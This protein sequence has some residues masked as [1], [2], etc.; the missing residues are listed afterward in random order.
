MKKRRMICLLLSLA[1]LLGMAIT[2]TWTVSA[3]EPMEERATVVFTDA[4]PFFP[5]VDVVSEKRLM[6]APAAA[7]ETVDNGLEL[8][9][10]AAANADGSYTI[11]MEAYTTGT[12]TTSTKTTPVD[13]VL[14]LDQSGSMA[15]G[16][17]G[18]STSQNAD[19][20][21][22]A[23]KQA[24]NNFIDAVAGKYS[25]EADHRMSIVTFGSAA[26]TLRGWTNVDENGKTTLK[27]GI[28]GLPNS[29]SG[30]T[31]VAAGMERAENL[32]GSGYRYTGSNTKRQKVVIVFTDG[33]P[34][35]QSDFNTTV[36]TN[37]IAS[38]K[39]L[40]DDGTTVYTVGIF[41]GANP[42][43]LYGEKWDYTIYSDIPCTG[44]VG[45]YWGGS[46]LSS[47]IGTNDFDGIDIAAGNRFLNYL[48]SNSSD[49]TAIGLSRGSFNPGNRFGGDGTGYQ[50]T[51]NFTKSAANYYLTAS[52]ST[53]LNNIFQTISDNIQ[54]ANIDLGSQTVVKDT[55]SPYFDLPA[56]PS[57]INLYTAEARSDGTF[58]D[59]VPASGVSAA[60]SNSTVSVT[61]FDYNANFVSDTVKEDGTY[62]RK[63]IIEFAVTPKSG[64]IGGNDVPTN[65]WE[66]S[67]VYDKDD[68][69][70]EQFA[71][72][73]TT[74]TVNVPIQKPAFTVSDRTIYEGNSVAVSDLY[75]LPDTTG[76]QYDFVSVNVS[77]VDSETVSAR[78]CTDYSIHVTYAP[79]T[80]GENSAGTVNSMAG[81]STKQTVSVHVLKPAVT[82][83]VHDVEKYYGETYELGADT[84]GSI[85]LDWMDKTSGHIDIPDA[86]GEP[87]YTETALRFAYTSGGFTGMVP[88]H[89][90][91][92][93]VQIK[94]DGVVM[95][96]AVIT[97]ICEMAGNDCT[98]PDT[99]G[100]YT[101]HVNTCELTV[102]KS[103]GVTGEP[104]VFAVYKGD[105][106]YSEITMVGNGSESL[107]ELPVGSYT[108]QED[109]GWSWRYI[110]DNGN[111]A[112]LTNTNPAGSIVCTNSVNNSYWL[113]GFSQVVKNIF[114]VDY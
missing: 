98:S 72:A 87:P 81:T 63:L 45:S 21:Q 36:A 102:T 113:N 111:A 46:W 61:G 79:K 4:G 59:A 84:G 114:G 69:K 104:Y 11:R 97:T 18:E 28:N 96:D 82:A 20:R 13:I 107:Y 71:D 22:Y 77:G 55:V 65:E 78:D 76:W 106:K 44:A 50:I 38:G 43:E 91:D 6:R 86:D 37:A 83:T 48:S 31:N 74:P 16:F 58:A 27:S 8:S 7:G 53:S 108:I 60:I 64:F 94:K 25:A 103:G 88:K 15:Y 90:F 5:P 47:L 40:K 2:R 30:A 112:L 41:N 92:V 67:A 33:V 75:K 34:T 10:T 1:L 52:D 100:N 62:G 29:P 80:N 70:V 23:M 19:R 39:N 17:D 93:A 101:V 95:E 54:T 109:A 42:N 68:N 56:D 85:Q 14:V 105:V 26:S 57:E 24:V 110:T 35:T 73:G 89:D 51:E 49:A 99:D 9:K 3:E 32:M 12:V 66:N